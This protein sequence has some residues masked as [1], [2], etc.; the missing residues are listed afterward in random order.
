MWIVKVVTDVQKLG[1]MVQCIAT[2]ENILYCID[3]L[4]ENAE[5]GFDILA[6][7]VL[8]PAFPDEELE[9][10][11]LIVDLQQNE[12]PSEVFSRDLVQRAAYQGPLGN[13]QFCPLDKVQ[14][15]NAD[16]LNAY[17][18]KYFF[19]DN[20]V[21]AGA[22]IDHDHLVALT[23]KK[24]GTVRLG[25]KSDVKREESVYTGGMLTNQR[26]LKEPF[27]KIAM[28]FE[29]GG[30]SS[31]D[32][33]PVCVMQHLLGGGSSF[34]AGGPGKGMYTRLY[35][36]VLNR[37]YFAESVEAF[38]S[39][40]EDHGIFGIDGACPPDSVANLIRVMVD[41]FAQLANVPVTDEEL[42][43]AKNM[44]KS[45]MMMQLESR[46]VVCED[47]ARQ[48]LTYGKR[49]PPSIICD[50]IDKVTKNDLM[51]VAS[52]MLEKSPSIGCVGSDLTHLPQFNDIKMFTQQYNHQ[53]WLQQG[54]KQQ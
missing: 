52:L 3:V 25:K 42:S 35:T 36:Q 19:G 45:M 34:S 33:V 16:M 12:L 50:K 8:N 7:T 53:V 1:G 46:L 54:K 28:A 48:F 44:L 21:V 26:E 37:H 17:R 2:R 38:V 27:V 13:H 49:D 43:R 10:S 18:G 30:W 40:H 14:N 47:I 20:C 6:D 39:I 41:Q 51:R 31:N 32:L 22:G 29:C 15:V 23:E 4:R 24:F 5:S 11:R 9:E